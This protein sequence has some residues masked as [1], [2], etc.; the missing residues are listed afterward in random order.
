MS[1][2]AEP[3]EQEAWQCAR[4]FAWAP[5]DHGLVKIP[6]VPVQIPELEQHLARLDVPVPRRYS[7]GGNVAWLAWPAQ[8]PGKTLETI[9]QHLGRPGLAIRGVWSDPRLGDCPGA[10]FVR[11]L[12][13]V[14]D[15]F[16][17][18][19]FSATP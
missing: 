10:G 4:E 8:I 3:E 14:F 19:A 5:G 9:L 17:K 7:V 15:P 16:G 6:L 13:P 1:R 11:R 18:F 12:Q 2:L